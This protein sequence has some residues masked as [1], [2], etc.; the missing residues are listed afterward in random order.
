M[1]ATTSIPPALREWAQHIVGPVPSARNVS[2]DRP[3][4]RVWELTYATGRAFVK[5]SPNP[6]SFGRETRAL[7]EVAPALQPGTIPLLRGADPYQRALLLSPVA[8]RPG[9]SLSLAPAGQRA[10]HR[11]A[12]SWLR[13]FHGAE[14][15]LCVQD[16]RDAAAEITLARAGAAKHLE[17]AGDLISPAQRRTVLRHATELGTV[18]ALPVG[19][20]HGDFQPRNWPLETDQGQAVFG[21]VD[22]ERARPHAVAADVVPLVCGP[23]AGHPGL[24][25]AFWT[26]Y[27]RRLTGK[28]ER[29]LRCLSALDAESAISWGVPHG[30]REI[31]KR[32][33]ATLARLEVQTA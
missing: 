17:R 28:E 5:L 18:A 31:V 16:R 23:W 30:D 26:G 11:Q 3:N 20:V 32:G 2:H 6:T 14:S 10:L 22:L 13:I 9:T 7:R 27:G 8:G 21:S 24:E 29:V 12:G 19:Y 33:R 15:D 4:S 25:E 1:S